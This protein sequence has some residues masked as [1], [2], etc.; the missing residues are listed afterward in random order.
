KG[1]FKGVLRPEQYSGEKAISTQTEAGKEII[2]TKLHD[3]ALVLFQQK[4]ED[5]NRLFK[6]TSASIGDYV[7]LKAK[8][9]IID[10]NYLLKMIQPEKLGELMISQEVTT[11]NHQLK[12]IETLYPTNRSQ[13]IKQQ[14]KTLK[15]NLKT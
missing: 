5:E 2:S 11:L 12:M 3:N 1:I 9:N 10:F 13:E 7:Q 4:L 6:D 15:D 14:I 8:F